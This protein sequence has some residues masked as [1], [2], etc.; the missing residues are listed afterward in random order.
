METPIS[1]SKAI[2]SKKD[3]K[4]FV[5]DTN[6]LLHNHNAVFSFGKNEVVIPIIVLEEL[7]RF[8]R[9]ADER[10]RHARSFARHLDRLR[11]T[12]SLQEGVLLENGGLLRV[13]LID[14]MP[15][16]ESFEKGAVDNRIL[17]VSLALKKIRPEVILITKDINLRVKSDSLG[18]KTQDYEKEKVEIETIY[19][20]WR[21]VSFPS[22][23]LNQFFKEGFLSAADLPPLESRLYANEGIEFVAS[24]N[25]SGLG[26][27]DKKDNKVNR[28]AYQDESIMGIHALNREQHFALNLL[29]DDRIQLVTLVG[30]AGTGKTL[31]ALAASLQKVLKEKKYS[32]IVVS[33]PIIPMGK[34]IGYLPGTKEEKLENW[35]EP[36]K[37]NLDFIFHRSKQGPKELEELFRRQSIVLEALTYSRGRSI[38]NQ[39]L[40]IDEV[41]NLTPLEAKTVIS[42]A[43]EGAKVI[44]TGDP[45]QIDNPYLDSDSNGLI[46]TAERFKGEMLAGHIILE[47]SERSNLASL[48]ARLL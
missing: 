48:A 4:T 26:I 30:R 35:M 45:W 22:E 27:Y 10:G 12:G 29:L 40:L 17:G 7:D 18:L 11:R 25:Q 31:L 41:Q 3:L 38:P 5:L 44:L 24:S 8:K 13:D 14:P 32:R 15:L 9:F 33:R 43:G 21:K 16:P 42:R 34:D 39:I 1:G 6:V 36:I 37:D 23:R 2:L 19:T 28:L 47:K 46:Y 20:G